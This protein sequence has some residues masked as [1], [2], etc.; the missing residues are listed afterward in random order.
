MEQIKWR[1]GVVGNIVS[2]HTDENGNVY[3]GTKAFTPGTK[4]YIN[5]K[6]WDYKRTEIS[7]IGRNRFGRVVLETVPINLIENIRTQRIYTP[8]VLEIIDY[9]RVVEGWEWWE[10]TTADRKDAEF[11]VKNLN[12][13]K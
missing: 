6:F 2:E 5:G 1:F 7:V 12:N 11:F 8:H 13:K 3:Y 4:V 10:R 9:L